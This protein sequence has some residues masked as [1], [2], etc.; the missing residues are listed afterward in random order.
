MVRWTCNQCGEDIDTIDAL[1]LGVDLFEPV[2][3]GDDAQDDADYGYHFC[4]WACVSTYAYLQELAL[5]QT[6]D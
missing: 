2:K 4:G 1:W 6:A 5:S 3:E